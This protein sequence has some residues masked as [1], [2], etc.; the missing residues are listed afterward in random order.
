MYHIHTDGYFIRHTNVGAHL[1]SGNGIF[2]FIRI[3]S[4]SSF[5]SPSSFL[6]FSSFRFLLFNALVFFIPSFISLSAVSLL[7]SPLFLP[8]KGSINLRVRIL[9]QHDDEEGEEEE[10]EGK[11]EE[12]TSTVQGYKNVK[13]K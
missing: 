8:V 3:L 7:S 12:K 2:L 6:D 13:E 1:L 11:K 4:I 9:S 5:L 10:E